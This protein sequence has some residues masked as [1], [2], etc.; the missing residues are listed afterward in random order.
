VNR[1][2]VTR[3]SNKGAGKGRHGLARRAALTVLQRVFAGQ[4]LAVLQAKHIDTID[5]ARDRGLCMEIVNGVLRWRWQLAFLLS[6]LL[7]KPLKARDLDVEL[8]LL[9]ALYELKYC[10]SP[11]YAVVNDAVELVNRSRKRWASSMVNA[12]LRRFQREQAQ[13][14]S[15]LQAQS[16][17]IVHSHPEWMMQRFKSDWPGHWQ[18]IVT[19]NNQRAQYYLRINPLQTSLDDYQQQLEMAGHQCQRVS[20]P[21][22][23]HQG[24]LL[25]QSVDARSLPGFTEGLFSVQDLSAQLAATLLPVQPGDTVLDLCAAPGGKTCHL[26]E[27]YTDMGRLTAVEIDP[28]RMRRVL[29]NIERLKLDVDRV[30]LVTGDAVNYPSWWSGKTFDKI[31]IDAPCSAS[32]V[33]RRHPDIKT[34]RREQDIASLAETQAAI[35]NAAWQMLKPGGVMLYATCSVFRDEN[36]RQIERFMRQHDDCAVLPMDAEWGLPCEY[37]RQI[38]PEHGDGFYYCLLGKAN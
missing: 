4:S 10:R 1:K 8:V 17:A 21:G 7:A 33:I 19:H 18:Q 34:L 32:G 6:Q 11:A 9:M 26:L 25:E 12:V 2:N 31:L 38:L 24:L 13:L 23:E 3:N 14:E 22:S 37:G 30:K 28:G 20:L 16:A 35:L 29:Q 15:S 5:D 27:R 36:E